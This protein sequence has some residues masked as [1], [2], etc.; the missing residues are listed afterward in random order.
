VEQ[1]EPRALITFGDQRHELSK[2]AVVLGRSKD[3][4][5]RVPDP[6]V[7]RRHAE[8]RSDGTTYTV[9]DLDSTNGIEVDGKR[10]KELV[11]EEGTRFTIGSTELVFSRGQ[12]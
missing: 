1:S 7:S 11:L 12:S 9:V 8:V 2:P 6:N 5:I 10:V 4:D 3:C